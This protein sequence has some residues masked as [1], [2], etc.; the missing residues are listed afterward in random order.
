MK[1]I[2]VI[3]S[4]I[5]LASAA[6]IATFGF[7]SATDTSN[8]PLVT[9]SYIEDVLAP[10]L[11]SELTTFIQNNFQSANN[12]ITTEDGEIV[13]VD[14]GYTIVHLTQDQKLFALSPTEI[15]LRSGKASVI[16]PFMDQGVCD[17]TNGG[18]LYNEDELPRYH[19]CLIPRGDDGRGIVA[20]TDEIYIMVR[21]EFEI[22]E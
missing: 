2:S 6:I 9:L 10:R 19:Y 8:D 11:K 12:Q 16:S 5:L 22:R 15:I 4:A 21:G 3:L 13:A 20:V 17:M 7:A 14:T 18:E 1:K